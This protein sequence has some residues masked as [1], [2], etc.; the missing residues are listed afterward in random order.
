MEHHVYTKPVKSKKD[1]P[2]NEHLTSLCVEG[3]DSDFP[4]FF[5]ADLYSNTTNIQSPSFTEIAFIHNCVF[6]LH[7]PVKHLSG[8]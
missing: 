7:V 4:G 2:A 5:S 1:W 6:A 8:K 3:S